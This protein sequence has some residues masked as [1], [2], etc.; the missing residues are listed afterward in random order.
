MGALLVCGVYGASSLRGFQSRLPFVVSPPFPVSVVLH[1]LLRWD[2][3][4]PVLWP[5]LLLL[6]VGFCGVS[7]APFCRL[8]LWSHPLLLL[9]LAGFL[10]LTF[11]GTWVGRLRSCL[12]LGGTLLPLSWLFSLGDS[13]CVVVQAPCIFLDSFLG[14]F[15]LAS[16]FC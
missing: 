1:L 15:P 13:H 5:L 16:S 6:C 8:G 4:V 7:V 9:F 3:L 14:F 10:P 2:G 11:V 12:L